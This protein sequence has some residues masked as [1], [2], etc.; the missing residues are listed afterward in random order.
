MGTKGGYLRSNTYKPFKMYNYVN[1]K[2]AQIS[3]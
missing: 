1:S 2:L 3:F